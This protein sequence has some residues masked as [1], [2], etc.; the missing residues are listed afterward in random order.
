M[1]RT[2]EI[3]DTSA[4]DWEGA[5]AHRDG[6]VRFKTIFIGNPG[7]EPDN[8]W[9]TLTN[10]D[11]YSTPRHRH[12]FDQVRIMLD[13]AFGFGDRIQPEGTIAYFPAGMYYQQHS[14]GPNT[15]LFLQCE[16]AGRDP[17]LAPAA[18]RAAAAALAEKGEFRNGL[19]YPPEEGAEPKDGF[20]AVWES[21]C[22]RPV[23]YFEPRF[24]EPVIMD[25]ERFGFV[26][27]G[28]GLAERHLGTFTERRLGISQLR[29]EAGA[30]VEVVA[31]GAP[32][33]LYFVLSGS[34]R[35]ALTGQAGAPYVE[36]AA[37]RLFGSESA[38]I[39]ATE[40]TLLLKISLPR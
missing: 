17:Y 38:S 4:L 32:T 6:G 24:D 34:G 22:G 10:I 25:P 16:G 1:T 35:A 36:R 27:L 37:F 23:E 31:D 21:V 13:G 20:E 12:N 7:G 33:T 2:L 28:E 19:Y 39:D 9:F 11:E 30:S 14:V 40:E 18:T 26:A 8:Y 5:A 3:V 15:H 29:I